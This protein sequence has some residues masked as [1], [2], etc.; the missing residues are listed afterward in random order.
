MGAAPEAL[1]GRA[2]HGQ[3]T[4]K[5]PS[6]EGAAQPTLNSTEISR[7]TP[8]CAFSIA[9][10]LRPGTSTSCGVPFDSQYKP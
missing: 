9:P 6:T 5:T 7:Q 3:H 10:G 1:R 2:T 4:R 8:F